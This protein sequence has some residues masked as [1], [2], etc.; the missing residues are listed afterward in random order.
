MTPNVPDQRRA[1]LGETDAKAGVK[2]GFSAAATELAKTDE[3]PS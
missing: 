1:M 3:R 2:A